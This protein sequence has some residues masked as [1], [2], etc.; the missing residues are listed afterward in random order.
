MDW[1]SGANDRDVYN[2]ADRLHY[3]AHKVNCKYKEV[4][5]Q[6]IKIPKFHEIKVSDKRQKGTDGLS[7]LSK[8]D[9]PEKS[10]DF[11]D[12]SQPIGTKQA[13]SQTRNKGK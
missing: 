9:N 4:W 2:K 12:R 13:K 11:Y 1:Q 10:F 6:L 5:L 3:D 7:N 8:S